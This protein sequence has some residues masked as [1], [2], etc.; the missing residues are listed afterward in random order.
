MFMHYRYINILIYFVFII[1]MCV[2]TIICLYINDVSIALPLCSVIMAI[3]FILALVQHD[4]YVEHKKEMLFAD[5]ERLTLDEIYDKFYKDLPKEQV[6]ELWHETERIL[7]M[8][9]GK[10]RPLDRFDVELG[11]R[12]FKW[13]KDDLEDELS[14]LNDE[15][16]ADTGNVLH[17]IDDYIRAMIALEA[18]E[19]VITPSY[20][21]KQVKLWFLG[22]FAI[23]Y[24]L[25]LCGF[26]VALAIA[27]ID[28]LID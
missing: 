8:P 20:K 13:Q 27:V 4:K 11:D 23:A 1:L 26:L 3:A 5:R 28:R 6:I 10:L 7:E 25:A 2:Y 21:R 17:T 9:S 12:M 16:C 15:K 18:M 24:V 22:I 14:I 19:T